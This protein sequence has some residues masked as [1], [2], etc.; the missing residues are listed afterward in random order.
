[1]SKVSVLNRNSRVNTVRL[2][3]LVSRAFHERFYS[4]CIPV[5][6]SLFF[7]II[8]RNFSV[9]SENVQLAGAFVGT[10]HCAYLL[11]DA[12]GGII[13]ER[14]PVAPPY[15]RSAAGC[16]SGVSTLS[17]NFSPCGTSNRN[18]MTIA[19]RILTRHPVLMPISATLSYSCKILPIEEV[20]GDT[21]ALAEFKSHILAV[22]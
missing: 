21:K 19:T 3:N 4:P 6:L 1:M 11:S 15:F 13:A 18:N 12:R 9:V 2:K 14:F 20:S 8:V 5:I 10:H 16:F 17:A 7:F 22:I